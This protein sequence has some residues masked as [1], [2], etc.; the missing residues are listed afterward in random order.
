MLLP[1]RELANH[2]VSTVGSIFPA[3]KV[4][5]HT[6]VQAIDSILT[7]GSIGC[8]DVQTAKDGAVV[9]HRMDLH[10]DSIHSTA[11]VINSLELTGITGG[12]QLA[13]FGYKAACAGRIQLEVIGILKA[14]H[15]RIHRLGSL[16]FGILHSEV[17]VACVVVLAAD[18]HIAHG[19]ICTCR[20]GIH[21]GHLASRII[22]Q[23][24]S[25]GHHIAIELCVDLDGLLV[26]AGEQVVAVAG[27]T[28]HTSANLACP[29]LG[30]LT[31]GDVQTVGRIVPAGEMGLNTNIVGIDQIL[32][33]GRIAGAN[34]QAAI[35]TVVAI[36]MHFY[37]DR[38]DGLTIVTVDGL[39]LTGSTGGSQSA[40]LQGEAAIGG[41]IQIKSQ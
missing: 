19:Q 9:A 17:I 18:T 23:A 1:Y 25:H 38:A 5:F 28:D 2:Q 40:V 41:G 32:T 4:G 22:D 37:A 24:Y 14:N 39:E 10:A 29:T 7:I 36:G 12:N 13:I 15:L 35:H 20:Q 26:A 11:M 6:N 16:L 3:G 21:S 34:I 31:Q 33:V 27:F 8:T 30:E